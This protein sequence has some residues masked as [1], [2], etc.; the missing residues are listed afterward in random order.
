MNFA[1][2]LSADQ[3]PNQVVEKRKE[4]DGSKSP[5]KRF[6]PM[7]EQKTLNVFRKPPSPMMLKSIRSSAA[8]ADVSGI[9]APKSDKFSV[10]PVLPG[11]RTRITPSS[12]HVIVIRPF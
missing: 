4:L 11:I 12:P 3:L 8:S 10:L 5:E 9:P 7:E 2:Q 6:K 1:K